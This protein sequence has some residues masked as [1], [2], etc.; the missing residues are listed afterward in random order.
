MGH[1]RWVLCSLAT[2]M[3]TIA[4]ENATIYA[5]WTIVKAFPCEDNVLFGCFSEPTAAT[6]TRFPRALLYRC[7]RQGRRGGSSDPQRT[8]K[9]V[10]RTK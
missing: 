3:H 4:R 9:K 2:K 10:K 8:K 6:R 1:T 7:C 5:G